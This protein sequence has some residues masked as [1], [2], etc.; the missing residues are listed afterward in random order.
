MQKINKLTYPNLVA[1]NA[2]IIP[3]YKEIS[4]KLSE[5]LIYEFLELC[6][7]P[8]PSGH[9]E[10]MRQYLLDWGAQNKIETQL[11]SSGCIYMDIPASNEGKEIPN[12]IFQSHFDMVAIAEKHNKL[13]DPKTSPIETIYDRK[14]GIIHTGWTTSLGADDG[15]GVAA[16]LAL[17]KLLCSPKCKIKHGKIRMLYTYDEETTLAGVKLLNKEVINANYL[18]NLDSVNVG[19]LTSSSAGGFYAVT[20]KKVDRIAPG[21]K[22][23][24]I[25]LDLWGLTGGH[26]GADIDKNRASTIEILVD[27]LTALLEKGINFNLRYVKSGVL[28]NAIPSKMSLEIV[29]GYHEAEEA[30]KTAAKTIEKAQKKYSDGNSIEHKLEVRP[31]SEK[32]VLTISDS[33]KIYRL[34]TLLPI[35]VIHR[36]PDGQVKTSNNIGFLEIADDKLICEL[37]YRSTDPE[38]L[39]DTVQELFKLCLDNDI[40]F[41]IESI[42][43]AWPKLDN[44]PLNNLL[45]ES[46]EKTSNIQTA[47]IDIHAGLENGYFYHKN[48]DL[49][50]ASIGCDLVNEHSRKE[51]LFTKSIPCFCAS[52]LYTIENLK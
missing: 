48:P 20:K 23:N 29:V 1:E 25:A 31:A 7:I 13:F 51:T 5:D 4:E 2:T 46:F 6:K 30:K 37:L 44:N 52:L 16:M 19:L 18:I 41:N 42:F 9:V 17:T 28:M 26:S 33:M 8:H 10:K 43:H 39:K 32:P 50:M 38:H 36:F 24:V 45:A 27:Y 22:T 3:E 47:A 35:G 12:L 34:L 14:K 21:K 49:I 40:D 11:D 15:S